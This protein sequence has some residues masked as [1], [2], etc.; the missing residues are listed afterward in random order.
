MGYTSW[1]LGMVFLFHPATWWLIFIYLSHFSHHCQ[2][3]HNDHVDMFIYILFTGSDSDITQITATNGDDSYD[4]YVLPNSRISPSATCVTGLAL[5]QD[6]FQ[7][8][9]NVEQVN[10][11]DISEALP[12]FLQWLCEFS[13]PVL[14]AH[15]AKFDARILCT[16]ILSQGCNSENP[17]NGFAD[18][19]SLLRKKLPGRIS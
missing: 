13:N 16:N 17:I 12:E 8:Y 4:L 10:T 1:I 18:T 5:S 6:G 14:V 2:D 9:K 15:T 3:N 7:M 11:K 19:L